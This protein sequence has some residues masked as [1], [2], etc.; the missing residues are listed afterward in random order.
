VILESS[1][2]RTKIMIMYLKIAYYSVLGDRPL[3]ESTYSF[4]CTFFRLS[5]L[6]AKA[7]RRTVASDSCPLATYTP[8]M[9]ITMLG[10]LVGATEPDK[11]AG[12]PFCTAT[13]RPAEVVRYMEVPHVKRTLTRV[14]LRIS[15]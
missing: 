2:D 11:S 4:D 1:V 14:Q 9:E 15:G 5:C 12:Q 13:S 3:G 6:T 7:L 8:S 10:F